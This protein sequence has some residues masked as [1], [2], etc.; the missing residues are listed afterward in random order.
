M[1][2]TKNNKKERIENIIQA[3]KW[4]TFEEAE[5]LLRE[6]W[7][8]NNK[9]SNYLSTQRRQLQKII[10]SD[11]IGSYLQ[12]ND[13]KHN[14]VSD[15]EWYKQSI[16]GWTKKET[17]F[18]DL[19]DGREKECTEKLHV[20]P[21]YDYL[22]KKS[23]LEQSIILS[24]FDDELGNIKNSEIRDAYEEIHGA[25]GKG[26][27]KYL[28]TEPYLFALKNEVER[29][30]YPIKVLYLIPHSP[31]EINSKFDQSNFRKEIF[32]N[33]DA[34]IDDF[35]LKV[36][37]EVKTYQDAR[38][39]ELTRYQNIFNF[40]I[41]WNNIYPQVIKL[42]S[43]KKNNMFKEL[44]SIKN[45]LSTP[46]YFEVGDIAEKEKLHEKYSSDNTVKLPDKVLK[47]KIKN[48]IYS[49]E[50]YTLSNL[51]LLMTEDNALLVQASNIRHKFSQF[52]YQYLAKNNACDLIFDAMQDAGI[53]DI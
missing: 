11:I 28:M 46:F 34:L 31:K 47:K 5:Q 39:V 29:R 13:R 7:N 40:L 41:G 15:K 23:K 20:F 4:F 12:I 33:I 45:K 10:R 25:P 14:P 17:F 8:S 48:S 3:N 42:D 21:K 19:P 51:E 44:N 49:F 35:T 2:Y 36:I 18:L 38:N 43:L 6:H 26:K 52:L 22:F 27:T 24:A 1:S 53:K 30:E 9:R 16:Y 50:N 32:T 37:E